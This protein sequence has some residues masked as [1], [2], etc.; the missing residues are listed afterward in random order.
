MKFYTQAQGFTVG[1]STQKTARQK[2]VSLL[3]C[4]AQVNT[5]NTKLLGKQRKTRH[6]YCTHKG[7]AACTSAH[8]CAHSDYHTKAFLCWFYIWKLI[9]VQYIKPINTHIFTVNT[10]KS[11][12]NANLLASLL[13]H[14]NICNSLHHFHRFFFY[15]PAWTKTII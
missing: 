3:R 15:F 8:T 10:E 1:P 12:L 5:S 6:S 2:H 13:C 14:R 7:E 4:C 9:F 11:R